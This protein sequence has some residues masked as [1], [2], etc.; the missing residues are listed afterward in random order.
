MDPRPWRNVHSFLGHEPSVM[1][2]S[3]T[4]DSTHVV[5]RAF[6]LQ[7][8]HISAIAAYLDTAGNAPL[9]VKPSIL[10]GYSCYLRSSNL[11]A[12]NFALEQGPHTLLS[13]DI[14]DSGH[15]LRINISST[16]QLLAEK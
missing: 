6:P 2:K 13:R 7:V 4:K 10:I 8:I 9:C 3:I 5:K 16:K 1:I 15:E 12:P 14:V 11:V